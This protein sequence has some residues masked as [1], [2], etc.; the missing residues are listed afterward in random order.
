MDE[1]AKQVN[2]KSRRAKVN[3]DDVVHTSCEV[4]LSEQLR[5]SK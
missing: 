2:K 5:G 3:V 1:D 4:G